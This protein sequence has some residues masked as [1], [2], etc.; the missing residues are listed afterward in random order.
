[1]AAEIYTARFSRRVWFGGGSVAKVEDEAKFLGAKRAL[2]VTDKGVIGAG[3]AEPVLSGLKAARVKVEVYDG[4]VP[5]PPIEALEEC[6]GR[7]REEKFDLVV[8]LGG[9]SSLDIAKATGLALGNKGEVRDLVGVE[10]AKKPALPTIL[11]PTTAGT[12]AESTPNTIFTFKDEK[13]KKAI[14]STYSVPRV[15]IIDAALTRTL[16]PKIT[17]ATGIDALTHCVESYVS[18]LANPISEMYSLEGMRLISSSLREAVANGD[19]MAARER[20]ALGSYYGGVTLSSSSAAAVHALAYPLGGRFGIPHGVANGL[21]FPWVMEFSF[22]G[23]LEKYTNI[24]EAIGENIE[25][26]SLREAA[27]LSVEAVRCLCEDVGVPMRLKDVD[28]PDSVIPEL[29]D[30]AST[31]TR[32][33][34]LNPRK[35]TRDDIEAIYR[36][37]A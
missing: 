14:V 25:G 4:C 21:M 26:L 3:L 20:M 16:P 37:A 10:L 22:M 29:A 32:L 24:A 27:E 35:L 7:Y 12:G 23:N 2:F 9:G 5:E 28:I 30:A 17:A 11:I 33:L 15:A 19:N 31:L 1:M 13:V 36:Q 18:T 34:D 8:G 6:Y